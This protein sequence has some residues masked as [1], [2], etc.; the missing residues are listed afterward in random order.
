[1]KRI[2]FYFCTTLFFCGGILV[3]PHSPVF[4]YDC[5]FYLSTGSSGLNAVAGLENTY[6]YKNIDSTAKSKI[7]FRFDTSQIPWAQLTTNY[8]DP[9]NKLAFVVEHDL[10][11]NE[12][13]ENITY[14]PNIQT[15]IQQ[16]NRANMSVEDGVHNVQL[17]GDANGELLCEGSYTIIPKL[18]CDVKVESA[19]G[20]QTQ[21][22][23][24]IVTVSNIIIQSAHVLTDA[25][26]FS[27]SIGV[28]SPITARSNVYGTQP[29]SFI[30]PGP[31]TYNLGKFPNGSQNLMVVTIPKNLYSEK[32]EMCGPA[33]FEVFPRDDPTICE[34]T[35]CFEPIKGY[36]SCSDP[37]CNSCSYCRMHPSGT[38]TPT[39]LPPT[40]T[41]DPIL[42]TTTECYKLS[43]WCPADCQTTCWKCRPSITPT[44]PKGGIQP[45]PSL[46]PICDQLPIQFKGDCKNC[47]NNLHGIWTAIG[48]LPVDFTGFVN[49]YLFTYGVG[50]AGGIAFLYFLY[51]TFLVMTSAG[52]AEKVAE[53]REIII[54]ALSGLLLLIFSVFILRVIGVDILKLPGFS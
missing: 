33:E 10:Y 21:D 20:K 32:I 7:V 27:T 4:A 14:E 19:D 48:C 2:I 1:M 24:W 23:D 31:F 41:D 12:W 28:I 37:K 40:P 13:T 44:P 17:I 38:P 5:K 47:A 8:N 15:A 22:S 39:P 43:D 26:N 46:A 35:P 30:Q 25:V 51:G 16:T 18:S 29:Q 52:V 42:C 11:S 6:Y 45:V 53:G 3:H 49:G 34:Q 36:Y 50:I 9:A 54:S